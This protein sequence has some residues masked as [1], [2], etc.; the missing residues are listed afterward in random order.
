MAVYVAIITPVASANRIALSARPS[1][2]GAP[3]APDPP[4]PTRPCERDARHGRWSTRNPASSATT[5]IDP[6]TPSRSPSTSDPD[7]HRQQRRGAARDRVDDR[8][9]AAPIGGRQQDEV[10]RLDEPRREPERD[11]LDRQRG[12]TLP[13]PDRDPE[14]HDPDRRRQHP[15]RG[16]PERIACGLETDVPGE[17][18]DGRDRDQA[19]DPGLHPGT[20]PADVAPRQP[21]RAERHA[22]DDH[23]RRDR[24]ARPGR[25]C[26]PSAGRGAGRA[27]AR[28]WR[29]GSLSAGPSVSMSSVAMTRN[30]VDAG[31][32]RR[33]D[34]ASDGEPDAGEPGGRQPQHADA[35]D[36][37][38]D[39]PGLG[40]HGDPDEH[41][42][43][44]G[45]DRRSP[46]GRR[47]RSAPPNSRGD[48]GV[49]STTS[50]RREF[51]SPAHPARNEA[52][53]SPRMNEP[54]LKNVSWSTADG[55]VRSRPG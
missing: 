24:D 9:V 16:R 43:D 49:D 15:D 12:S 4:P 44:R 46:P 18:E 54:K 42:D 25:R 39:I 45:H 5:P 10:G 20:L 31:R 30:A 36:R 11:P 55:C 37:R 17:M 28:G 26:P 38:P 1:R 34:Q 6:A 19:D 41:R 8:Q 40:R 35:R 3:R 32:Q 48:R 53:A 33:P 21:E 2:A 52:P 27:T 23:D 22:T 51:S 47:A 29:R 14:R 50:S 13:P 7:E